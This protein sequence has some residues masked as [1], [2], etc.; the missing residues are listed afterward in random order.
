MQ[1]TKTILQNLE[2][3]AKSGEKCRKQKIA[4]SVCKTC[5]LVGV[6]SPKALPLSGLGSCGAGLL[7]DMPIVLGIVATCIK[8]APHCRIINAALQPL[9]QVVKIA[10]LLAKLFGELLAALVLA[11]IML[12]ELFKVG[13]LVVDVQINA[14]R[15]AFVFVQGCKVLYLPELLRG[16]QSALVV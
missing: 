12:A 7:E 1:A 9:R 15:F 6:V 8:T 3:S 13:F 16:G 2:K 5:W 4:G 14:V 11:H 10:A